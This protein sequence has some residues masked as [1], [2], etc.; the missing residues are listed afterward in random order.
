MYSLHAIMKSWKFILIL[1]A[2]LTAVLASKLL[3]QFIYLSF[4]LLSLKIVW[5]G[6]GL[7][8][9]LTLLKKRDAARREK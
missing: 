3:K 8:S 5:I 1:G 2:I 7:I 9:I 6:I 4:T